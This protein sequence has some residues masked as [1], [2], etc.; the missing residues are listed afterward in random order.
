VCI[1]VSDDYNVPE[2]L[3]QLVHRCHARPVRAWSN[4]MSK[5]QRTNKEA[6]KQALLTPKERKSAKRDKKDSGGHAIEKPDTLDEP[7]ELSVP[8][9]R[10]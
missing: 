2:R 8:L 10:V 6:K 1:E 3:I 5:N 7:F 9:D 4:L